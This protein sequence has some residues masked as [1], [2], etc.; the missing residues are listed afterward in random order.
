MVDRKDFGKLKPV[1]QPPD[2]I[3]IQTRSYTDFLQLD[4][5]PGRRE[6]KGLQAIFKEV[7][8]IDSYDGR[9]TLDFV[10]FELSEP[11]M[12][13]LEALSEGDTYAAPLH[14]TFRLKDGDEI[15]EEDVYMGEIPLM[16]RD[17]AFVINGAERVIVSQ[18]HRS[19]G[20]CS[21]RTIHPN[22]QSLYSVRL[23]PD[24]GSWIEIQFDTSD[25]M[26]VHGP[27]PPPS[28]IPS[29]DVHAHAG[30]WLRRKHSAQL[31]QVPV[32]ECQIA[33]A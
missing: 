5:P 1:S 10:K 18:L 33:A 11:K 28:E 3:E 2:L 15:R 20:I 23:I 25:I 8:P 31:L 13:P 24:R 17:G 32:V 12:G 21:E 7:F 26:G 19:P 27:P 4:V 9:Y 6:N 29:D 22:G 30:L 14:A 16:T